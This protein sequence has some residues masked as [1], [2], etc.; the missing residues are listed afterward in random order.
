MKAVH[1]CQSCSDDQGGAF[2]LCLAICTEVVPPPSQQKTR[3]ASGCSVFYSPDTAHAA[4]W[5]LAGTNFDLWQAARPGRQ[6]LP[7]AQQPWSGRAAGLVEQLLG[8]WTTKTVVSC[9]D[10]RDPHTVILYISKYHVDLCDMSSKYIVGI[11]TFVWLCVQCRSCK[12]CCVQKGK[13]TFCF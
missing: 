5:N 9:K 6:T 2:Y 13:N 12:Q 11:Q 1:L 7:S 4:P 3:H 10:Q 8:G